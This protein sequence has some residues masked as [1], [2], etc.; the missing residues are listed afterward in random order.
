MYLSDI[1]SV[2]SAP[3]NTYRGKPF[4]SWNG[5]LTKEELVRQA[6]VLGQMGFGGYFMHS[7]CGLIT[8]YLGDEW[9]DLTNAV[10]D[11]SKE[12]GLEA[13]L[14]DEDRWPSGSA[15]GKVTK[16]PQYRQ[17]SLYLYEYA[18]EQFV[19]DND[20]IRAFSATLL[21]DGIS[22]DSY[23]EIFKGSDPLACQNTDKSTG[24]PK[25]LAFKIVPDAPNSNYNGTTY[26][27]TMSTA[28]VNRFIELTHDEYE[29]RC[30]EHIGTSIK[31]IFT[32]E[33]IRNN[34]MGNLKTVGG[35]RSCST[36]Y[37]D[38]IFEEF[39]IRYGYDAQPR[40][41]ELFYRL[42]GEPVA[43]IRID[44]FDLGC[45]LFNERFAK[46]INDWC[47]KHNISFTGHVL[48]EDSLTTQAV[49]NGSLM[50]FYENMGTP[51]I[52]I[53]G[54]SN[55]CYWAAKQCSSVCR[56]LDKKWMLSELYGCTGWEFNFRSHKMI[57]DWQA[58][59]GVNV[60][61][62]HLSWYTMEGECKRDYPASISFQSPYWADYDYV[63]S[64]FARL[65]V[66]LSEGSPVCDLL[67][68][69]PIES[70]W[71]L[72]H[73]AWANWIFAAQDDLKQLEKIYEDLFMRLAGAHI[74]FDYGE[75]QMMAQHYHIK[76]DKLFIGKAPYRTVL[77]GGML[78]IRSSTLKILRE[79]L[80]AGGC[81]IFAGDLPKYVDGVPSDAC[82][83]LLADF[84]NAVHTDHDA[85]T[86]ILKNRESN[87]VHTTAPDT[88]FTQIRHNNGDYISVWLNT[89]RDRASGQ[90][91]VSFHVPADHCTKAAD[92]SA[93][94]T[95]D[96]YRAE[97][98]IPESGERFA[99]PCTIS[100]GVLSVTANLEAAGS[101]ILVF[102]KNTDTLPVYDQSALTLTGTLTG[103]EYAY[104]LDEP[105]V[106]VLDYARYRFEQDENF[107]D[108]GEVLKI[109][110]QIRDRIGIEHR[111]GAM[112][113]P[114]FA[115]QMYTDSYG[116]LTLE[117]P[118][119]IETLPEGPVYLA[120]E[121]PQLQEYYCNGVRLHYETLSDWWVDNA[122]IKM[123]IPA[124][125][126]KTGH[127]SIT[128]V[129][130]FKR[131][132]NTEAIYLTGN[133]G[134][135][136]KAGASVI[137][138]LPDTLSLDDCAKKNL[139]F[140]SGKYTVEIPA[141]AYL[142]LVD[143]E[144]D[145]FW[146]QI[147]SFTGALATVKYGSVKHRI[148]WEPYTAEIT[149][150]VKSKLPLRIT[151]VNTRRNSFGPLHIVPTIQGAYGPNIS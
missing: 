36:F 85:C 94:I 10:A 126:L 104:T 135:R 13:W 83:A 102:T 39:K 9:F 119:E 37:T 92:T 33:P 60:R 59:F 11:A 130:D 113:Q 101:M 2:F 127:N 23:T 54:N 112:L 18:P 12:S 141:D 43:K 105:N 120:G 100:D 68:L 117:Y 47:E 122:F 138:T 19:W 77:I 51:G 115:K 26:I 88:V 140:Y 25:I 136:A 64:Y 95:A 15:G 4:W 20:V 28:A 132:T 27:D 110:Q 76:E 79:F 56:Q 109:D 1:H 75:E 125:A 129:T 46:P 32:D 41:P 49:P 96:G 114:W 89:D 134:V 6:N 90:F 118:F 151:M 149:E 99:Y 111:G 133:F 97:I 137:T 17:K 142:P 148:A 40:M 80:E 81:V 107:S 87:P 7:R 69:N 65:G 70:I 16:D 71:A 66:M 82:T 63:E 147:P 44:Y 21:A 24:T 55:R 78:T 22:L 3:G 131:T 57:G 106:A 143:Q 72:S 108:L 45:N 35:V 29:K 5:E 8:E 84:E 53:L 52:D 58:L 123:K 121:R 91:T 103:G 144:A 93:G 116:R 145:R 150:A 146:I 34:A 62:P 98:W 73:L 30:G 128:I 42:K 38:D 139:P 124:E 14:Y 48:H 86:D 50:R 67:V 74:D 61:C 31:G